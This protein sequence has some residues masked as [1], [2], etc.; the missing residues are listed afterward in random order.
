MPHRHV[1]GS[2]SYLFTD[3]KQLLAK[4]SPARSGDA[5]AG[6]AAATEEERMAAR[7]ALAELPLKHFLDEALIPYEQDEVTRLIVDR[8]AAS[9]FAASLTSPSAISATGCSPMAPTPRC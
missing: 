1:I 5:L 6:L 9:A 4:A 2:R 3:L 8:H 7:M